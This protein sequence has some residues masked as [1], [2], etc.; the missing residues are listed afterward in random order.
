MLQVT[1]SRGLVR[2]AVEKF[3]QLQMY[4]PQVCS[5]LNVPHSWPV[6]GPTHE[7]SKET[8]CM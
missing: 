2:R 3:T 7:F 4:L 6:L 5:M 8:R 1:V